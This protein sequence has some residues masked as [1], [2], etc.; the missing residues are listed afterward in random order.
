[1]AS[2]ATA[3]RETIDGA[4]WTDLSGRWPFS[5]GRMAAACLGALRDVYQAMESQQE[6]SRA[7]A[8]QRASTYL[9]PEL[10]RSVRRGEA[11]DM[12]VDH[13]PRPTE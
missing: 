1:M 8:L 3:A 13:L 9:K 4:A 5:P 6:P 7:Q 12:I 10:M 2:I 11:L